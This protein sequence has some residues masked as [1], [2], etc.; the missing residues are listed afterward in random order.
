MAITFRVLLFRVSKV[1]I[2]VGPVWTKESALLYSKR[3]DRIF[4]PLSERERRY[5]DDDD[6]V[7]GERKQ[8]QQPVRNNNKCR[9]L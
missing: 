9:R 3:R 6:D 1:W 2:L 7:D 5:D 4:K 8:Q